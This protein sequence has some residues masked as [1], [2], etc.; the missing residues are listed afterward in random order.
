MCGVCVLTWL[1]ACD[2]CCGV[3]V[4]LW[5]CLV[6]LVVCGVVGVVWCGLVSGVG[7]VA[8]GGHE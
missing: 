8:S 2:V 3:Y 7:I 5:C 1:C 4:V 6:V